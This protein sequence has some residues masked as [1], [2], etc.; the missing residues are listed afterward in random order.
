MQ[1]DLIIEIVS[2]SIE[3][4]IK[5]IF[6]FIVKFFISLKCSQTNTSVAASSL[7]DHQIMFNEPGPKRFAFSWIC[8]TSEENNVYESWVNII[9][10]GSL[11]Q[12]E[13]MEYGSFVIACCNSF[14]VKKMNKLNWSCR[15]VEIICV[16]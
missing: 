13:Q 14:I 4:L 15:Y 11:Q 9:H 1:K 6:S 5:F 12:W 8:F 10:V 2:N 16:I 3:Q 7:F